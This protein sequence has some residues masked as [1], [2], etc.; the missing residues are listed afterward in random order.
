MSDA[1]R[2]K[3]LEGH[4]EQWRRIAFRL[5]DELEKHDKET[6]D[7]VFENAPMATSGTAGERSNGE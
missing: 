7:A 4:R 6:A 1:E 2:I 3:V 5:Y